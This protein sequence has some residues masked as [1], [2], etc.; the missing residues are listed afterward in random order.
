[1]KNFFH[2]FA[3]PNKHTTMRT[4]FKAIFIAFIIASLSSCY[5]MSDD[6]VM[7]SIDYNVVVSNGYPCYNKD[8][9]IAYYY[10][11]SLYYYPYYYKRYYRPLPPPRRHRHPQRGFDRKPPKTHSLDGRFNNKYYR[12]RSFGNRDRR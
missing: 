3:S 1:M 6:G 11:N 8:R 10:Y 5:A 9:R 12:K 7:S 4:I 2:I